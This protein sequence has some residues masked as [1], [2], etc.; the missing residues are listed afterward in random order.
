MN[1]ALTLGADVAHARAAYTPF[2]CDGLVKGYSLAQLR[3]QL[4]ALLVIIAGLSR[5]QA[6]LAARVIV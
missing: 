1:A 6:L 2:V 4:A 5:A 3:G